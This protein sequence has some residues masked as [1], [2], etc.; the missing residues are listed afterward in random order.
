METWYVLEDGSCGDPREIVT[1]SNGRLQHKDGRAVVY[2]SD[3][4]TP[5]SRGVDAE[6]ERAKYSDREVT[7]DKPKRGYKTR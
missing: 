4:E 1:G 7:A 2:R 5:R 3:G 6:A